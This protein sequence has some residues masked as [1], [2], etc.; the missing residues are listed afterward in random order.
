MPKYIYIEKGLQVDG[1]YVVQPTFAHIQ[2]ITTDEFIRHT[3]HGN[4]V[5]QSMLTA[6]LMELRRELACQ[7]AQGHSVELDGIGLFTPTLQMTGD[8]T[9]F[10]QADDGTTHRSNAQSIAFGTVHFRP[11]KTLL[12]ECARNCRQL[13]H[14]VYLGDGKVTTALR[15]PE[16]RIALLRDYLATNPFIT[17]KQYE[18]L[19]SLSHSSAS[20]E[21][22]SL[23]GGEAPIIQRKGRGS[24]VIY[25]KLP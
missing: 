4:M 23:S 21:L 9:P 12:K 1:R 2:K 13:E 15:T 17:V 18:Q 6:A 24:H 20:R 3:A 14:D 25:T 11:A 7:L 5:Q 22:A 16:E 10:T 8:K 19:A